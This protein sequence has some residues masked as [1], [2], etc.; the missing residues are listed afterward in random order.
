[1]SDLGTKV[2]CINPINWGHRLNI[3]LVGDYCYIPGIGNANHRA[4]P[5]TSLSETPCYDLTCLPGGRAFTIGSG[6]TNLGKHGCFQSG[7]FYTGNNRPGGFGR[8]MDGIS[9]FAGE[10]TSSGQPGPGGYGQKYIFSKTTAFS[11]FIWIYW[12]GGSGSNFVYPVIGNLNISTKP[13]WRLD[14]QADAVGTQACLAAWLADVAGTGGRKISQPQVLSAGVMQLNKWYHVGFTYDGSDAAAGLA[15]YVNGVKVT[16][17]VDSDTDPGVFDSDDGGIGWIN[18]SG[19]TDQGRIYQRWLSPL[20][21][22]DLYQESK[23]GSPNIYRHLNRRPVFRVPPSTTVA[24]S[25]QELT[26]SQ[27]PLEILNGTEISPSLQTVDSFEPPAAFEI[28]DQIAIAPSLQTIEIQEIATPFTVLNDIVLTPSL[29]AT[30]VYEFALPVAV[31]GANLALTLQAVAACDVLFLPYP[32][33]FTPHPAGPGYSHYTEPSRSSSSVVVYGTEPGPFKLNPAASVYRRNGRS[34][35]VHLA[36]A[37]PTFV[38]NYGLFDLLG[39]AVELSVE[40]FDYRAPGGYLR[41]WNDIVLLSN[42]QPDG[43]S[44]A[45]ATSAIF[46]DPNAPQDIYGVIASTTFLPPRVFNATN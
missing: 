35:V 38:E 2:D 4:A 14:M 46:I 8:S 22:Y 3:G 23:N 20:D 1:M 19:H 13:G 21:A 18:W 37:K 40:E 36:Q 45:A 5:P 29:Q 11:A 34:H 39:A 42:I 10:G 17:Q 16:T 9:T 26:V 31:T 28:T 25:L 32:V 12:R 44:W 33:V 41:I 6:G 7:A 30:E 27:F 43:P 15:I 24:A